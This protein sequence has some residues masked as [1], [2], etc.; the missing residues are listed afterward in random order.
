MIGSPG[1]SDTQQTARR[2]PRVRRALGCLTC[3]G[4]VE[5]GDAGQNWRVPFQKIVGHTYLPIGSMENSLKSFRNS[6]YVNDVACAASLCSLSCTGITIERQSR[7]RLLGKTYRTRPHLL[8]ALT[9]T[10]LTEQTINTYNPAA[11]YSTESTAGGHLVP[12][13]MRFT[14]IVTASIVSTL[15]TQLSNHGIVAS[16]QAESL[17]FSS[18]TNVDS[19]IDIV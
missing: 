11:I 2:S 19:K 9:R 16:P 3:C 6:T 17:H 18:T 5:V 14:A 13:G 7:R 1:T 8:T 12:A 4:S 15:S 10:L